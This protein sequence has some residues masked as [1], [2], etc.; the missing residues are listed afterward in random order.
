[1]GLGHAANEPV[2]VAGSF[3]CHYHSWLGYQLPARCFRQ[4]VT[5]AFQSGSPGLSLPLPLGCQLPPI[6]TSFH[7][8]IRFSARLMFFNVIGRYN[9][10]F[11]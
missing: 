8:P 11:Q 10:H 6:T 4:S 2:W 1:L 3:A 7:W 5:G 9:G